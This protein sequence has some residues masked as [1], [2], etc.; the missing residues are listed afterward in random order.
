LIV[1]AAVAD[2]QQ[3]R[4]VGLSLLFWVMLSVGLIGVF[5]EVWRFIRRRI[6]ARD[7][8]F[9]QKVV[10]SPERTIA[11]IEELIR[12]YSA[13]WRATTLHAKLAADNLKPR[14]LYFRQIEGDLG[15]LI[16]IGAQEGVTVDT[17]LLAYEVEPAS[18]VAVEVPLCVMMVSHVQ[19]QGNLTQARVVYPLGDRSYWTAVRKALRRQRQV[20]APRNLVVPRIPAQLSGLSD[21]GFGSIIYHLEQVRGSLWAGVRASSSEV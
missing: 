9:L 18:D 13:S 20:E 3:V 17:P 19:A 4:S 21:E 16:D 5:A 7:R 15:A 12:A 11:V 2:Y 6:Q 1:V 14:V 10:D 8:A